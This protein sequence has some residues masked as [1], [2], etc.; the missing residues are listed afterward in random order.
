MSPLSVISGSDLCL[1]S[2]GEKEADDI[3][4][5]L[6]ESV[7]PCDDFYR[8]ACGGWI[9]RHKHDITVLRELG[10]ESKRRMRVV[11]E[12]M[13]TGEQPDFVHKMK[14][15]YDSCMDEKSIKEAG[16]EPLINILKDLGGWPVLEGEHWDSSSFDWIDT[17]IRI[18]QTGASDNLLLGLSVIED[19]RDNLYYIMKLGVTSLRSDNYFLTEG[20]HDPE[21]IQYFNSMVHIATMLGANKNTSK[22]E[23]KEVL[24]FEIMLVNFSSELPERKHNFTYYTVSELKDKIPQIDWNKFFNNLLGEEIL[25]NETVLVSDFVFDVANLIANTSKRVLSNYMMW[26]IVFES[27]PKLGFHWT[28]RRKSCF[29]FIYENFELIVNS[30][31][32]RH[33]FPEESKNTAL[34]IVTYVQN[35]Y[36]NMLENIDWMDE[37]SKTFALEK[38]DATTLYI[39]YPEALL[40]DS[41]L[42]DVYANLVFDDK[43]FFYNNL[44]VGKWLL[45]QAF[46]RL[47][48]TRPENT[49]MWNTYLKAT[50]GNAVYNPMTNSIEVPPAV[51]Q[52]PIFNK[53][54]PHYLNFGAVG[55][56]FGHELIHG[57]SGQIFDEHFNIIGN[58]W[59]NETNEHFKLKTKC[60]LEQY[61]NYSVYSEKKMDSKKT[62]KEDIADNIAFQLAYQAYQSWVRDNGREPVLPGLKYTPN[63]LFWISAA[64]VM[65]KKLSPDTEAK[66]IKEDVHSLAQFR[67]IGSFSNLPEFAEDFNCPKDSFMNSKI[68]CRI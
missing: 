27:L 65:C 64:N 47:R 9:S 19:P 42:S 32:M 39:G 49:H 23:L 53:D 13:L 10:D 35:E 52:D 12:N 4:S 59:S 33:Y 51:F 62:H 40:N 17:R 36:L 14:A 25:E 28:P 66:R 3:L 48:K 2:L 1:A 46:S 55:Y 45:D 18:H 43:S 56:I 15:I 54:R 24:D 63:Q 16:M 8:F 34:Q 20:S 30:M 50:D 21:T 11:L 5:N 7:K 41:Y 57:F 60:F 37:K 38:A 61:A 26:I 44:N 58:G 6:D 22:N 68:R 31:Y 67:V 29:D